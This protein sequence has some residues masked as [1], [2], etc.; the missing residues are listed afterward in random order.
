MPATNASGWEIAYE[1]QGERA[2]TP[3]VLTLGLS[4]RQQHW[5]TL[6]GMLAE[7]LFMVTWDPRNIGASEKRDEPYTLRDE[8]ADLAAVLDAAG[9]EAAVIYGRSRGGMLAQEFALTH[10]ERTRALVLSGT[11]RRGPGSVP[12]TAE[13]DAAM[14]IRPGTPREEIFAAQNAAM[15]APGWRERDPEAFAYCMS[16]DLEAPPRRFAVRRQREAFEQWTSYGRLAEI[17]CP[18]L[19]LCGEDDGM[20][21][22]ENSRQLAKEIAGAKLVLVPQCGHLPMLE[23]PI[24]VRNAVFDFLRV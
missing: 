20:V 2:N 15:A 11:S 13:V 22:P 8:V 9:L 3:I 12:S 23:Q 6:P 19:V 1:T 4:H 7:R 17:K 24:A 5:G 10:P 14:E 16:I 18:V 21:P